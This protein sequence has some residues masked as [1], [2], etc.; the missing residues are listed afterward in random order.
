MIDALAADT[1]KKGLTTYYC[2][3]TV[4]QKKDLK[5]AVKT[6]LKPIL[7]EMETEPKLSATILDLIFRW[8]NKQTIIHTKY[9]TLFGI[10]AA[11][12]EQNEG[13]GWTNFVLGRWSPKWQEVQQV[14]LTSIQ[15]RKSSLRWAAAV[16]N[17]L[18][19]TV[20]NVWDFRNN[21]N[22]GKN[23]PEYKEKR[24]ELCRIINEEYTLGITNFLL[25]AH[26]LIYAYYKKNLF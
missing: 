1:K 6:I 17:K 24:R 12:K 22:N 15:S 11:I 4:E 2:V 25:K 26:H 13:L 23:G 10:R 20:W 9:S 5:K 21:I 7:E 8:R 16:I 19:M 18:L 14:Y 3:L